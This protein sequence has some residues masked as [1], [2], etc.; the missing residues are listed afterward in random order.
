MEKGVALPLNKFEFPLPKDA[1][2]QVYLKLAEWFWRRNWKC[3]KFT[4]RQ[5]NDGE[6]EDGQKGISKAHSW[7]YSSGELKTEKFAQLKL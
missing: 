3:E 7:A 2:C 4:D 6:S 1:L 5:T